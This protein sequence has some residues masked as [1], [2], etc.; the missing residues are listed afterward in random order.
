MVSIRN[1]LKTELLK[2]MKARQNGTVTVLR[3]LLAA[4]DNAEAVE[5]S[6]PV[7]P[8]FGTSADVPRKM[9]TEQQIRA[10]VENEAHERRSARARYERLGAYEAVQ[11]M[12]A[13]LKVIIR[14][15][16]EASLAQQ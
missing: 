7:E 14:C 5:L 4:I 3:S 15:L 1:H 12:S 8:V 10:V 13:E 9:L 11:Q 16:E 2:A 6:V